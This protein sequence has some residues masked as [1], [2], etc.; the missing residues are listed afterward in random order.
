MA[1]ARTIA[2]Q[3]AVSCKSRDGTGREA[4]RGWRVAWAQGIWV[5]CSHSSWLIS[6]HDIYSIEDLKQLIYDLKCPNPGA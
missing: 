3:P 6:H 1:V 4:L 2:V 5:H